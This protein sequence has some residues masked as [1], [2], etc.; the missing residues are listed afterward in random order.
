MAQQGDYHIISVK[1]AR[2]LLGQEGG[3]LSDDQITL[4]I[5]TLT[6]LSS[7]QLSKVGSRKPAG[8]STIAT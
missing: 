4:L 5:T 3:E 6:Q 2:K 8:R 7:S 1:E